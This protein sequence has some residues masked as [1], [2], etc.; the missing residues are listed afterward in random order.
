MFI[1]FLDSDRKILNITSKL[2]IINKKDK[3]WVPYPCENSNYARKTHCYK[4]T[5]YSILSVIFA[6]NL[7]LNFAG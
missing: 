2:V 5:M 4:S 6:K 1:V 3:I 7:N